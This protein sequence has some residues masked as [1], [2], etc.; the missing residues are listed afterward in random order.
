MYD[1]II[2]GGGVAGLTVAAELGHRGDRV[3]L[4]DQWENWGGRVYTY[5]G[6]GETKGITYEI[7]AGR[8]FKGH[9]RVSEIVKRYGLKTFPIGTDSLWEAKDPNPFQTLF[10][11]IRAILDSLSP[12]DLATHTIAELLPRS[13]HP[14]L[15]RF[16]YRAEF[17]TLRADEALKFFSPSATMGA[18]APDDYYGVVGGLDAI[19]HGLAKEATAAGATLKQGYKVKDVR[20]IA[21]ELFEVKATHKDKDHIF[22]CRRVIFATCRCSL[23]DFKILEGT[24]VL[25]QTGT[26]S[27]TRIYAVYPRDPK[28]GKAWFAD[29]PKVVTTNPLRYVIPISA[30]SGLI[31]ISYTDS[32]DTLYWKD[33]K[34]DALQK[35]I[36]RCARDLFPDRTIPEPI[37]LKQHRWGG[38][39][40]Y[41]LP[42]DYDVAEASKAA[43]NP[44]PN[45]YIV[46]ESISKTQCWIESA[47][48]SA[49][50][51]L[52]ILK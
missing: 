17:F 26:E 22:E 33:L 10:A 27:L 13:V 42:G 36:Q 25:K 4:M 23:S 5:H 47:L 43:H 15:D 32:K 6:T 30:K 21:E 12:R 31:M 24:P 7:G 18:S 48:E 29:L 45:V 14:I 44:A 41:W 16:P 51:L 11:P 37:Y 19:P 38:G 35:E 52:R 34:G 3:L 40:T 50:T 46:G 9:K 8:I 2:V 39:C 20:R 1:T 28:T 49:E